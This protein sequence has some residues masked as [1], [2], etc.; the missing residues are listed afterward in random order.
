MG[1][2]MPL[3]HCSIC[4]RSFQPHPQVAKQSVCSDKACQR[5][6]KRRWQQAKRLDDPDYHDNQTRSARAWAQRN[7]DY[8]HDYRAGHPEYVERNRA[9][10][11]QRNRQTREGIAKMVASS[12]G[13]PL[14]TGT[15]LLRVVA[16]SDVAK[17]DAWIVEITALS[18]Q[19]EDL[20]ADCKEMT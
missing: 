2:F 19:N 9:Q 4:G 18:V 11:G 7:P 16:P 6:R 13:K 3:R 5:E 8:W 15:Y 17:M 20:A 14:P 10:Q 1:D 12:A